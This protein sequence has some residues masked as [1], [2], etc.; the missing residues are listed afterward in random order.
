MQSLQFAL[1]CGRPT[2]DQ[3]RDYSLYSLPPAVPAVPGSRTPPF[4]QATAQSH[5]G[6]RRPTHHRHSTATSLTR[7]SM[8]MDNRE[9]MSEVGELEPLQSF[10]CKG[11][12]SYRAAGFQTDNRLGKS[13]DLG[14]P[15]IPLFVDIKRLHAT[16]ANHAQLAKAECRPRVCT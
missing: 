6:Q 10:T 5:L 3:T 16:R 4:N 8:T 15:T 14:N 12:S 13:F 9:L 1:F 11:S 2:P 7:F